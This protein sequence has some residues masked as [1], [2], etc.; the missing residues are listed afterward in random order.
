MHIRKFLGAIAA[1]AL[2]FAMP[3]PAHAD[4]YAPTP[5]SQDFSG[6]PGG[7]APS[8][9]YSGLCL[10]TLVCPLV[11]NNWAAG[12]ADGNGFLRTSFAGVAETLAG[13]SVGA[14][15]SPSFT[16]NGV[17]GKVPGSVT[18]DMNILRNVQALLDLT[19][20]NDTQYQVDLVDQSN[21]T[22]ISVVPATLIAPNGGW[23]AIPSASVNPSLLTLGRDYR[24]QIITT[25]HAVVTVVALGEVGYDNVRL[26]TASANGNNGGSGITEI[27]QLRNITKN[28]ILPKSADVKGHLLRVHL[29]CPA[30]ASPK[31][32]Q[33]QFAGL[34]SG[35]F[36]KAATARKVVKLR[37]G[38][39]RT[40]KIRIKPKYVAAYASAKK[41]WVKA[42]VRVGKVRV[43]VRKRMKVN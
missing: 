34:Q 9:G 37:A 4:T 11:G 14:W 24:I 27:K 39:E 8:T 17:A 5:A 21:G 35:K 7:W 38:K 20:L 2:L 42:I 23:T 13:T 31:P 28:Y 22:R 12:G 18:F 25:Y 36:S 33:I 1:S 15:T 16:Y 43:T 6:G 26:T 10:P 41:I 29:R 3:V 30:I 19:L 40:V 32:C